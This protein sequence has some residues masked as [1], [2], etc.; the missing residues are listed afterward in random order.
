M[1]LLRGEQNGTCGER[2]PEFY[3]LSGE[4]IKVHHRV[5]SSWQKVRLENLNAEIEPFKNGTVFEL[6]ASRLGI[7]RRS[8]DRRAIICDSDA[9]L[10]REG[11][12]ESNNT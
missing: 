2:E 9:R 5:S 3:T 10:D 12:S 4:L 7:P 1:G 11:G 6:I 8:K